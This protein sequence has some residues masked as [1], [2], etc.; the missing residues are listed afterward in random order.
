MCKI[1]VKDSDEFLS[2]K[3]E[4]VSA[5]TRIS[6]ETLTEQ[7]VKDFYGDEVNA[8]AK[9][10]LDN[11]KAEIEQARVA[12]IKQVSYTI[13][14]LKNKI[15][16]NSKAGIFLH[17]ALFLASLVLAFGL[18][19]YLTGLPLKEAGSII[20]MPVNMKLV[21]VYS[22]IVFGVGLVA[23]QGMFLFLQNKVEVL[24]PENSV[25]EKLMIILSTVFLALSLLMGTLSIFL[26]DSK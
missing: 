20:Q 25:A 15:A 21:L 14:D 7:D 23:K 3:V 24:S 17:V 5:V 9:L 18:A 12:I 11:R 10:K 8:V 19:N 6:H 22:L 16:M 2:I 26:T 1:M 13:N 4:S